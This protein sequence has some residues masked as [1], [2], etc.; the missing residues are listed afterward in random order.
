MD[1]VPPPVPAIVGYGKLGGKEL[2]YASDLDLVFAD[3]GDE[4][5][6]TRARLA[7]RLITWLTSRTAAGP[8]YDVDIRLPGRR[9]GIVRVIVQCIPSLSAREAWTWEHQL[10]RARFVTGAR[11]LGVRSRARG[12]SCAARAIATSCIRCRHA[13][14]DATDIRTGPQ[15]ST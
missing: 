2:G 9:R 12:R 3:D 1:G 11:A 7:H 5:A 6:S 14:A 13:Q 4:Q 8:L 10:T 15:S